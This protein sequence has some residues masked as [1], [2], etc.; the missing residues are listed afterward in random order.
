M[1]KD[2]AKFMSLFRGPSVPGG[3]ILDVQAHGPVE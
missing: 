2:V 3:S 1:L